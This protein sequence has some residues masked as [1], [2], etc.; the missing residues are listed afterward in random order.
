MDADTFTLVAI[1]STGFG[2]AMYCCAE[3]ANA[4]AKY[5]RAITRVIEN[6]PTKVNT[7]D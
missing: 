6:A 1:A 5:W 4:K 2:Y 7:R 3:L